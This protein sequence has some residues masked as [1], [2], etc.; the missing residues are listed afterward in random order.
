MQADA[1]AQ[2][3]GKPREASACYFR[4]SDGYSDNGAARQCLQV[5]APD[6]VS[7]N[8]PWYV[9][10]SEFVTLASTCSKSG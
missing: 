7:V 6:P 10:A 3:E 5:Q 1:I 8:A 9:A 4:A 2:A